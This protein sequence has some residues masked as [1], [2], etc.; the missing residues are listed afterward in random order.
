MLLWIE[1]FFIDTTQGTWMEMIMIPAPL[2]P[3]NVPCQL[4]CQQSG[5]STGLHF[6]FS[7]YSG[8]LPALACSSIGGRR[9]SFFLAPI[10]SLAWNV[11]RQ[12][13]MGGDIIFSIWSSFF[14]GSR[15]RAGFHTPRVAFAAAFSEDEF[16]APYFA[17]SHLPY[18]PQSLR[19]ALMYWTFYISIKI[20]V[21]SQN[22]ILFSFRCG[23][24]ICYYDR[25]DI[26]RLLHIA[27]L[28]DRMS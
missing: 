15:G 7:F 11:F 25:C 8:M 1:S 10:N 24:M 27:R 26:A 6:T 18:P 20:W 22:V 12:F 3:F 16:E 4:R 23:Q 28:R 13:E 5:I 19:L 9:L 21:S 2:I 17:R 14:R